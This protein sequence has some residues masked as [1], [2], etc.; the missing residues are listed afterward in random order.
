MHLPVSMVENTYSVSEEWYHV[1][2][3]SF[4]HRLNS[5]VGTREEISLFI[6]K[7]FNITSGLFLK[8][9]LLMSG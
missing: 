3:L 2:L 7:D 5:H 9:A 4:W 6:R 8:I 1:F